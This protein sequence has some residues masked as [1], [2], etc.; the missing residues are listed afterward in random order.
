M[1][2]RDIFFVY[3]GQVSLNLSNNRLSELPKDIGHLCGLVELFIQYNFLTSLPVSLKQLGLAAAAIIFVT[4]MS[5][6]LYLF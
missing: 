4:G 3:G 1:G 6:H 2:M 5:L